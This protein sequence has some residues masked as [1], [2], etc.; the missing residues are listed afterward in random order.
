[1]EPVDVLSR[2]REASEVP[3]V[4]VAEVADEL[5]R[6]RAFAAGADDVVRPSVGGPELRARVAALLRRCRPAEPAPEAYDDGCIRIDAARREVEALGRSVHLTPLEYRL[7]LAFVRNPDQ[8]LSHAQL[9]DLAWGDPAGG[10]RDQVKL[11]VGQLRRKLGDPRLIA[12]CRGFGY[13]YVPR[14][15]VLTA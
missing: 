6:V 10:S 15:T 2:I 1:M 4:L 14:S 8:V 9:L 11:Y 12:T 13:R 5:G 3:V 7:L